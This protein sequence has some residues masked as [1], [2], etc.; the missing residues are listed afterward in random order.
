MPYETLEPDS[1]YVCMEFPRAVVAVSHVIKDKGSGVENGFKVKTLAV[2]FS[3]Y[4]R[5]MKHIPRN[6]NLPPFWR[7]LVCYR[8][9]AIY[10]LTAVIPVGIFVPRGRAPF[11]QHQ[12]SRPLARSNDIPVL[13]GFVNTID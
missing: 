6:S 11:G 2:L 5:E 13:N 4:A 9:G 12:E 3:P 8:N 10:H 1:G 7:L